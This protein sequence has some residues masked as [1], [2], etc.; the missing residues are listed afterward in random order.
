MDS[1]LSG[2]DSSAYV[3]SLFFLFYLYICLA[4]SLSVPTATHA[5]T[6]EDD[7]ALDENTQPTNVM[8]PREREKNHPLQRTDKDCNVT[9]L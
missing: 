8:L 3:C 6:L 7:V 5:M 9:N 2:S 1:L 4:V